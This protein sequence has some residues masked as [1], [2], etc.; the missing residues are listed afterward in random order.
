MKKISILMILFVLLFGGCAS[1]EPIQSKNDTEPIYDVSN[2]KIRDEVYSYIGNG[3]GWKLTL[4]TL[5]MTEDGGVT[6]EE[7]N[8]EEF[9]KEGGSTRNLMFFDNDLG[10]IMVANEQ[11]DGTKL[12]VTKDKGITFERVILPMEQ[13]EHEVSDIEEYDY[14]CTPFRDNDTIKI[15]ITKSASDTETT[16][17]FQTKD[18]G[19]T[20]TYKGTT[21]K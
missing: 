12:Y 5:Y 17:V 2:Y 19:E 7:I 11:T 15:Y 6:W 1:G 21:Y 8:N 13:C 3:V 18:W 14:I 9:L 16:F 4:D 10:F 20:W